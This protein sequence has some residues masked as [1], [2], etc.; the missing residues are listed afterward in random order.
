MTFQSGVNTE[1]RQAADGISY[2]HTHTLTVTL[3]CQLLSSH[4][5]V[6]SSNK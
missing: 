6:I 2:T 4:A 5:N 3:S 1:R